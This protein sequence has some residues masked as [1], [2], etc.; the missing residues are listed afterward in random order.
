MKVRL[1]YKSEAGRITNQP[2]SE[3]RTPSDEESRVTSL[4]GIR[5]NAAADYHELSSSSRANSSNRWKRS[6]EAIYK[7]YAGY[8]KRMNEQPVKKVESEAATDQPAKYAEA[9]KP[10]SPPEAE[11]SV[12]VEARYSDEFV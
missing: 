3:A 7:Q 8:S 11:A 5:P 6:T 12:I 9:D 10:D 2:S 4:G 1:K